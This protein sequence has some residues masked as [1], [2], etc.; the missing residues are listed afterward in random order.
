MPTP[1]SLEKVPPATMNTTSSQSSMPIEFIELGVGLEMLLETHPDF[2]DAVR[3]AVLPLDGEFLFDLPHGEDPE[4]K[5]R[6][7]AIRLPYADS[8][9]ERLAFVV[10]SDDGLETTVE[11][12]ADQPEHLKSFARSFVDVLKQL[13]PVVTH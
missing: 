10:L 13:E 12:A 4:G 7:A 8:E 1:E 2:A 11:L 6:I 9:D 3:A 5:G